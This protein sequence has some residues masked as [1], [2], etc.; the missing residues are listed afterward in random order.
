MTVSLD[1]EAL[2]FALLTL[3]QS[4]QK[5]SAR[6]TLFTWGRSPEQSPELASPDMKPFPRS[7]RRRNFDLKKA[8]LPLR[9]PNEHDLHPAPAARRVDLEQQP[10]LTGPMFWLSEREFQV[11]QLHRIWKKKTSMAF[12]YW[13]QAPADMEYASARNLRL[14][15]IW[16]LESGMDPHL[17]QNHR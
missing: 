2:S 13:R 5:M 8:N 6:V 4:V 15:L 17:Q 7:Q 9:E 12:V 11:S 3:Y 14:D 10:V 16:T 1:H